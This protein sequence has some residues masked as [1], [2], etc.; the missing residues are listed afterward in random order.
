[1]VVEHFLHF[2]FEEVEEPTSKAETKKTSAVQQTRLSC[3][4]KSLKILEAE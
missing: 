4:F 3:W 1:M 2:V